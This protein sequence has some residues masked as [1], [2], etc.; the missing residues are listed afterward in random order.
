MNSGKIVAGQV[1]GTEIEGS[2][3]GLADL[4]NT[5]RRLQTISPAMVAK[6]AVGWQK[7]V[8]FICIDLANAGIRPAKPRLDCRAR[9]QF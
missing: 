4:K 8:P 2:T 1:D 7:E 6:A 3:R 5:I 9:I